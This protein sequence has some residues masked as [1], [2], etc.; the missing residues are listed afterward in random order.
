MAKKVKRFK[1]AK[2]Y[3]SKCCNRSIISWS[4]TTRKVLKISIPLSIFLERGW[5]ITICIVCSTTWTG[6]PTE[7]FRDPTYPRTDSE[8]THRSITSLSFPPSPTVEC[9][10]SPTTNELCYQ[11]SLDDA[12][13]FPFLSHPTCHPRQTHGWS[14]LRN[15]KHIAGSRRMERE[16]AS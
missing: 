5:I 3:L 12:L 7:L 1:F 2:S 15:R 13:L 16:W 4:N 10:H 11:H 6:R 9:F 8:Q 14:E